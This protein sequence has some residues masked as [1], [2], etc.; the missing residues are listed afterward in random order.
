MLSKKND[1]GIPAGSNAIAITFYN[2]GIAKRIASFEN[3]LLEGIAE[4]YGYKGNI[5]YRALFHKNRKEVYCKYD[6]YGK[7]ES[8]ENEIYINRNKID[9]VMNNTQANL[10][11]ICEQKIEYFLPSARQENAMECSLKKEK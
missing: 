5:D 7:V 11:K 3:N 8:C 4:D 6:K 10:R 2:N 9:F 1:N